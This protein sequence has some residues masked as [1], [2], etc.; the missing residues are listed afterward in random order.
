[1]TAMVVRSKSK[2]TRTAG[3][4]CTDR[5]RFAARN[6]T[7]SVAN[8]ATATASGSNTLTEPVFPAP[9]LRDAA[10]REAYPDVLVMPQHTWTAPGEMRRKIGMAR[11]AQLYRAVCRD[12]KERRQVT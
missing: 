1:M 3:D 10:C 5:V 12:G 4:R 2:D 7:Y 11:S 8:R 9:S 6:E